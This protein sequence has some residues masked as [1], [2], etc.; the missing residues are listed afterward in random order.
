MAKLLLNK[1]GKI[2]ASNGK[3]LMAK[4]ESSSGGSGGSKLYLHRIKFHIGGTITSS[5]G[6]EE[7]RF[8]DCYLKIYNNSNEK[9]TIDNFISYIHNICFGQSEF[10]STETYIDNG[11]IRDNY[12]GSHNLSFYQ[13]EEQQIDNV[14]SLYVKYYNLGNG[15]NT[16]ENSNG[17]INDLK[18][19][20][21][22]L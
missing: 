9:F 7:Y 2:L 1:E 11:Y 15:F 3:V 20:V 12:Y 21:I 19:D 4:K 8:T 17:Y 22:E 18:D 16:T 13:F 14:T 5:A 10:Q 6:T